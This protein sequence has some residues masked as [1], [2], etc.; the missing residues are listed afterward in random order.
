MSPFTYN[1]GLEEENR[2]KKKWKITTHKEI[3]IIMIKMIKIQSIK[4]RCNT[5]NLTVMGR[6]HEL[7]DVSVLMWT[8]Y[9][10]WYHVVDLFCVFGVDN[11]WFVSIM[12]VSILC[13]WFMWICCWLVEGYMFYVVHEHWYRYVSVYCN[14]RFVVN[15][16]G[17]LQMD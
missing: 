4:T 2:G 8:M 3:I 9:H 17:M 16:C 10:P 6:M 14:N 12:W 7:A 1:V 5:D 15:L 11:I 13:L